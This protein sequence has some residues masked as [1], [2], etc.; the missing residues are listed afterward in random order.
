MEKKKQVPFFSSISWKVTLLVIGA[1]VFSVVVS[2]VTG[3]SEAK[4]VVEEV[5]ENYIL[6][7]AETAARLVER[8]GTEGDLS[9][10]S[11]IEMTG[12]ESSYAYL[13]S[14]DGTM[15][16]HPTADKIGSSVENSVVLGVVEQ[17]KA[18]NIPVDE[19]VLYDYH[20]T[21][22]YAAY[23]ITKDK[24]IV[25]VTADQDEITAPVTAMAAQMG[26]MAVIC[27]VICVVIGYVVSKFICMPLKKLI[28][29]ISSTSEFDFRRN[30][31]NDELCKRKD[32]SGEVARMVRVMRRN[33]REMMESINETSDLINENVDKLEEVTTTVNVMCTDNSATSEELAAGMQEA[34]ATTVTVNENIGAIRTNA[35]T[36]SEMT[37]AGAVTSKE[38]MDR[39]Q[40]L[41][42]K[43]VN[44]S[45]KALDMYNNVKAKADAAIEGSKAVEQINELTGTIMEISSQTGL[46]ALNASIEAARAGEA[47]KG[48]AVVATEIGSLADQTTK[49]IADISDIVKAVNSA[50]GN[51]AECLEQATDFLE[52][53]VVN[54]YKEFTNVSEQY[55]ADAD[56]FRTSMESVSDSMEKLK[57]AIEAIAEA[58]DG[59]N[60]T[61]SES[62]VGVG[63]IAEKTS[64][65]VDTTGTTHEQVTDCYECV[66]TL[67]DSVNR[68]ILR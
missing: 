23:A 43:A 59:I 13:V 32:E 53:T 37:E 58:I 2:L 28:I 39:A 62:A 46:L 31:L 10:L 52:N 29:V 35:A 14:S 55:Q 1:V 45:T 54:D 47:G 8:S 4:A 44:S 34:A 19:V 12:I 5:N 38:V 27:L 21:W 26:M 50:V 41:R 3:S 25:V 20:G 15:L 17:L 16:Y 63:D 24:Q 6:S 9:F 51:M 42:D 33:L 61:V 22:K 48:F 68:F 67:K 66:K 49:A 57:N 64:D 60:K 18:G 65:M 56:T 11:E 7:M 30:P 40:K 36:I